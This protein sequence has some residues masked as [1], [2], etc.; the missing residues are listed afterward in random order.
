[1]SNHK[2]PAQRYLDNLQS[3]L[4]THF[5]GHCRDCDV[6][7]PLEFAHLEPTGLRG[8]GRG[9][10]AR[11]LDVQRNLNSYALMCRFH[12]DLFDGRQPAEVKQ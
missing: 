3:R 2:T 9:R 8:P 6:M 11:L 7:F 1:M 5:G 4:Y 12:H 10:K